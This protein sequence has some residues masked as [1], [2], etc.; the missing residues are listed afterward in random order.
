MVGFKFSFNTLRVTNDG[1][2]AAAL[3][4]NVYNVQTNNCKTFVDRMFQLLQ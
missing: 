3:N 1:V 4:G 2:V